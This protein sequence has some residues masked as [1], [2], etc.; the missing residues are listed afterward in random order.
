[1]P[2][3]RYRS[4]TRTLLGAQLVF[5]LGFY[6]V[7]PFLAGAMRT[8]YGL[9]VAA[10]GFVLGART[11]SQQGM[12]LVGG[13]LADRWGARRA[14]LIGCLVRILGY[15]TLAAASDF[16]LFLLGAVL[17]GAGGALFSPALESRLSHADQPVQT[18]TLTGG[19]KAP[20]SVFVWLAVIGEIGAVL[21]PVL[22]SVLLSW[23]FDAA[24]AAGIG[25]FTAVTV[26]LW[27]RLPS[28][29][30]GELEPAQ[31]DQTESAHTLPPSALGC[32]RDRR[33]VL[34]C[35]LASINMLAY[36]QL[37]F[38]IPIELSR[39]GLD[40]A[41]LG[42]L[43]LLAS[44]LTLLLQLPVAA[45]GRSL[46]SGTA[47]SAGFVLLSSAFTVAALTSVDPGSSGASLAPVVI[48]VGI[49]ILG[50]ML[51]TPTI[52]SLIPTFA[53]VRGPAAKRG[54]Y[55][56]L[57]ATC[58]GVSVLAG[59]A[60]IGLLLDLTEQE[61]WWPGTPW[62]P[63]VLLPFLAALTLPRVLKGHGPGNRPP[64]STSTKLS[65]RTG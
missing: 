23:S 41:L 10:I 48:A 64:S 12:F 5:N 24:L 55:Y 57:A 36:N 20:R 54:A 56:G 63:L 14:I 53:A 2:F 43:F 25:I 11:F 21:G 59:N 9:G 35:V 31:A 7:V 60:A 38:A 30:A 34:F 49:L 4:E 27:Y 51:L 40:G 44:A 18:A 45:V 58:G 17:T 16:T 32:L 50:H 39:R 37:Y 62:I 29:H 33:F 42:M 8:E 52:L 65:G 46:G 3:R 13:L 22:G 19:Q 26:L 28:E 6:A 47:L 1:M 61:K 15:A